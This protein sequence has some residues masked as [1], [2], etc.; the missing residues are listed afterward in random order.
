VNVCH[1]LAVSREEQKALEHLLW[2]TIFRK[3]LLQFRHV[4]GRDWLVRRIE[5]GVLNGGSVVLGH[6]SELCET[7]ALCL[8][9]SLSS[10]TARPE[11]QRDAPHPQRLPALALR[12]P[13]AHHSIGPVPLSESHSQHLLPRRRGATPSISSCHGA[14]T[15]SSEDRGGLFS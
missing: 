10:S 4:R 9:P 3:P 14:T 13:T 12:A 8:P 7:M 1:E 15:P 6:D 5:H 2:K 11:P